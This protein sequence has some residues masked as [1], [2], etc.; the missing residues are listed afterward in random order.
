[1][2]GF[3]GAQHETGIP[4]AEEDIKRKQLKKAGEE[5]FASVLEKAAKV[6]TLLHWNDAMP[7]HS[8]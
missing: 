4:V 3:S 5:Y 7:P 2:L 8:Q 1:M 6:S